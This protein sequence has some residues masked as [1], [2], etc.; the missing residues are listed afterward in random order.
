MDQAIRARL[1]VSRDATA[2]AREVQFARFAGLCAVAFGLAYL[3]IF[4][5]YAVVGAPPADPAA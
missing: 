4:A 5:A 3:A 1:A 2:G